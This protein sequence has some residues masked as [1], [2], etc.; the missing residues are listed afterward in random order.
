MPRGAS[1]RGLKIVSELASSW[2]IRPTKQGKSIW[3][4]IPIT[5]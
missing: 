3:F 5:T 1:G 2:G 4:E